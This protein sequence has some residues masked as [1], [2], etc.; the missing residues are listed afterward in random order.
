MADTRFPW[1]DFQASDILRGGTVNI[2]LSERSNALASDT[3]VFELCVGVRGYVVAS[4]PTIAAHTSI[5]ESPS[6]P[7]GNS[8]PCLVC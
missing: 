5:P 6:L 8:I 1:E 2:S 7:I 4:S 3:N